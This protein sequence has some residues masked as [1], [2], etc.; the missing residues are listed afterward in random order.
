MCGF[1]NCWNL[2]VGVVCDGDYLGKERV[3][4]DFMACNLCIV[5]RLL[6]ARSF[7]LHNIIGVAL[8]EGLLRRGGRIGRLALFLWLCL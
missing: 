5:L 3:L 4:R 7:M 8:A 2:F 6:V 1:Q